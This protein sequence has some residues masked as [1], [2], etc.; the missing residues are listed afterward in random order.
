MI[1]QEKLIFVLVKFCDP[2]AIFIRRSL[3]RNDVHA[4]FGKVQV[5]ANAD[6]SR[7]AGFLQHIPYHGDRH[8]VRRRDTGGLGGLFIEVQVPGHVDKALVNR[9]DVDVLGGNVPAV[10][11]VDLGGDPDVFRH[12][13]NGDF[14]ENPGVVG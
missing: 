6:R 9:V 13:G 14:I 11:L 2:D 7:D 5:A 10:D 1:P 8:L 3:L 4:D 12:P